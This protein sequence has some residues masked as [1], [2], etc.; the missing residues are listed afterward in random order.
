M[1]AQSPYPD[2]V[3]R[4]EAD[5]EWTITG[6]VK[7]S[8]S[9]EAANVIRIMRDEIKWLSKQQSSKELDRMGRE[10]EYLRVELAS[11]SAD[12]ASTQLKL[13]EAIQDRDMYR[14]RNNRL[15]S[16]LQEFEAR[17]QT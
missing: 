8:L 13:N 1:D 9:Q 15:M 4:L 12:L 3:S 5:C 6:R 16:A 2:I 10:I 14:S 11:K 7:R 17:E